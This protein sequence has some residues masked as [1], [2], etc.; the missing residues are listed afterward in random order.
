M[1]IDRSRPLLCFVHSATELEPAL[2]LVER[3]A[4]AWGAAD[5]VQVRGKGLPAGEL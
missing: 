2:G 1:A 3:G 4:G 5:L